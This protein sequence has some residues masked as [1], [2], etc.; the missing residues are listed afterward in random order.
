MAVKFN[1]H[2]YRDTH[3]M[4]VRVE[5]A[6]PI[7]IKRK[8]GKRLMAAEH[9]QIRYVRADWEGWE[10][11]EVERVYVSGGLVKADGTSGGQTVTE[12]YHN[13]DRHEW[14]SWLTTLVEESTPE[15]LASVARGPLVSAG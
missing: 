12:R 6:E 1:G 13:Y 2:N 7:P 5:G 11:W 9:A 8:T 14:P 3:E 10:G 15:T 4:Y